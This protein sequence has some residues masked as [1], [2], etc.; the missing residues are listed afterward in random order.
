[1]FVNVLYALVPVVFVIQ[2]LVL[3][4]LYVEDGAVQVQDRSPESHACFVIASVL[5]VNNTPQMLQ[6]TC[7]VMSCQQADTAYIRLCHLFI[8]P[9]CSTTCPEVFSPMLDLTLTSYMFALDSQLGVCRLIVCAEQAQCC[10]CRYFTA[11][12][13]RTFPVSGKFTAAQRDLYSAVLQVQVHLQTC[14]P[15][16]QHFK[17]PRPFDLL[18]ERQKSGLGQLL[19]VYSECL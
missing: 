17:L 18:N 8:T 16:V 10:T 15:A 2:L 9:Y 7:L 11:D 14:V 19:T 13:S 5:P 12:I 3:R 4:V 1:M 6:C